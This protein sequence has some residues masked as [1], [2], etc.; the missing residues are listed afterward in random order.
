MIAAIY[1][2]F[3]NRGYAPRS[4]RNGR[5]ENHELVIG[6]QVRRVKCSDR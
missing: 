1:G 5:D 4:K 3:T 2:N 6:L